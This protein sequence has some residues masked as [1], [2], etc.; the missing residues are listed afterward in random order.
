MQQLK[1]VPPGSSYKAAIRDPSVDVDVSGKALSDEGLQKVAAALV[2]SMKHDGEY[3]KVIRLEDVCLKD[4]K[5]TAK[6]LRSLAGVMAHAASH[7][8]DLDLSDNSICITTNEEAADWEKFL[9]SFARCSALRRIDLSGNALG[10]RAF[11]ILARVYGKSEPIEE[12]AVVDGFHSH[13]EIRI[14]TAD[15]ESSVGNH[16]QTERKMSIVSDLLGSVY[17]RSTTS[18]PAQNIHEE[19]SEG[20]FDRLFLRAQAL[21]V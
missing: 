10:Q 4:N 15:I 11:E 14:G 16:Q 19:S 13:S 8:R 2:K 18:P 20:L 3:G 9:E 1:R 6:C 21:T 12:L 5:L 17:E 7:L